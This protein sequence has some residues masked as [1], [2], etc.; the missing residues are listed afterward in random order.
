VRI[1]FFAYEYPPVLVGGLG[2]YAENMARKFVELGH[3]VCVFSMNPGDLPTHETIKGVEVHRPRITDAS[4]VFPLLSKD[5]S[6]WGTEVKFFSDL[7]M[8][9]AL[10]ASKLA[11]S[12][13]RKEGYEFDLLSC[14]DW[15]NS[16]GG[17]MVKDE[18]GLPCVFH[19]HSTEWGRTGNGS[20]IISALEKEAALS[21]DGIVT[22]SHA[23]KRD[24]SKHGWPDEKIHVIWNGVDPEMYDPKKPKKPSV[25][26]LRD[27]Y[28][29]KEDERMVLFVGRLTWVKGVRNLI[30]AMPRVLKKFP[31]TKFVILGRGEEQGDIAELASRLGVEDKL[32]YRF[33]FV[34][35]DE[36]ILHYAAA[37]LCV[38]PSIYEPFGIVS[39]EAMSM[40]KPLVVGAKG[41]VGFAEQVI[42]SGPDQNGVH[43]D[44]NGPTDIAWGIEAVLQDRQRAIQWG[45]NGRKRVLQYFTWNQAAEHTLKTYEHILEK[46]RT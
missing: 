35:E 29:L 39:L 21:S 45:R 31:D 11:N 23:M 26:S 18:L 12:L 43:V 3:D 36:R 16:M 32:Y 9:N 30:Q 25:A 22:V 4:R 34:P 24:L 2:T 13:V 28:G 44:G 8:Y 17:M 46:V 7:F 41:V 37:D 20:S 5:L 27:N 1:A 19:T 14:H 15:L 33:E 42:P 40:E 10:S 6:S 38:F